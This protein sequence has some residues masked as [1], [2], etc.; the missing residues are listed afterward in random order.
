MNDNNLK[1]TIPDGTSRTQGVTEHI[2][3]CSRNKEEHAMHLELVLQR[4]QEKKLYA[5]FSKCE[6]WHKK[7]SFLG[8]VVS[9][10]GSSVDQVKNEAVN[11]WRVPK[12]AHEVR[13]FLGLVDYYRQ[14]LEG[15]YKINTPMT[16]LTY[17][18]VKF[19]WIDKCGQSFQELKRR[20]TTAQ[21]LTILN[22]TEGYAIYSD[23]SGQGLVAILKK[24]G[25]VIAYAS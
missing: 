13:C 16:F 11:Q 4:L 23:A 10:E 22:G 6:F 1:S 25:K 17:K 20:L 24:T 5:K 9:G 14:F 3:I 19:E 21:V 12:K 7:V 15:F 18:D 8:H 2:L